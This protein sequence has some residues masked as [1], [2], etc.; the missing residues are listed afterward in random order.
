[1]LS[2]RQYALWIAGLW[3]YTLLWLFGLIEYAIY[4]SSFGGVAK[5]AFG[6][7][8]TAFVPPFGDMFRSYERY[9]LTWLEPK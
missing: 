3:L 5:T 2:N 9:K 4:F 1:M 6:I 7:A 8:I